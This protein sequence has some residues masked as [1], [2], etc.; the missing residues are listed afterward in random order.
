MLTGFLFGTCQADKCG[1]A[2][3]N[4]GGRY[5]PLSSCFLGLEMCSGL[6]RAVAAPGTGYRG[7]LFPLTCGSTRVLVLKVPLH[8]L[9]SKSTRILNLFDK[10]QTGTPRMCHGGGTVILLVA[11]ELR[12][13]PAPGYFD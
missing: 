11:D 7:C 1:V 13:P 12:S 2:P 9:G 3:D 6:T 5:C 10:Q 8:Y 4:R